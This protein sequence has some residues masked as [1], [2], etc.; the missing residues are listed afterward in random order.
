MDA[1]ISVKVII[2]HSRITVTRVCQRKQQYN[3]IA[4]NV[5][6]GVLVGAK[7]EKENIDAIASLSGF[8]SWHYP[9]LVL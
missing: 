6:G 4:S 8:E 3:K 7:R 1:K 9:F 2:L 5:G